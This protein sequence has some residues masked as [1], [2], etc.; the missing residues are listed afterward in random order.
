MGMV[1]GGGMLIRMLP[2]N[3]LVYAV[4]GALLIAAAILL[5]IPRR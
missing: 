5:I 4:S 1:I 2:S 3:V